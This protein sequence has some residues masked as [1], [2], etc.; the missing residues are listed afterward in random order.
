[1]KKVDG[2]DYLELS[3]VEG[4]LKGVFGHDDIMAFIDMG[5]LVGF[6]EDGVWI[7]SEKGMGSFMD[8]YV[9]S[10][11][12]YL[13]VRD[14]DMG[15]IRLRG[16]VLD[17][18]GGGEGVIGQLAGPNVI[19]IDKLKSELEEAADCDCVK[20]VMDATEMQFT[21]GI[22]DTVTAFF[23]FMYMSREDVS[24]AMGESYRVLKEGGD[25]HVWD[26][27]VPE[28]LSAG[29]EVYAILLRVD[30]GNKLIETGYGTKWNKTQDME[31]IA[32]MAL[33]MGFEVTDKESHDSYFYMKL[34]KRA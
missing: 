34:K 17:I 32:S 27:C 29:K 24:R 23:S 28:N 25:L 33:E 26:M 3:D 21:D 13:G 5:E 2:R 31:Q 7:I 15:D 8:K 12:F 6:E 4:R 18:G 16:R 14:I 30:I 22:F 10:S 20:I 9:R 11:I 19:A 1:V